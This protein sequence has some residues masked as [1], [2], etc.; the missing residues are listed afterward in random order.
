M[1]MVVGGIEDFNPRTAEV[2][3]AL[4][5]RDGGYFEFE[6]YQLLQVFSSAWNAG[7]KPPFREIEK[8]EQ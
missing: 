8:V 6:L 5:S 7:L 1:K 3:V 4:H 2:Y